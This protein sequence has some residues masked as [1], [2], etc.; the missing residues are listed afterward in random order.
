MLRTR[1]LECKGYVLVATATAVLVLLGMLGL[2]LDL[3]R[4]YIIKNE[5]QTYADAAS[6]AATNRLNGTA[7]GITN[8]TADATSGVN[9][10]HL[11]TQPVS[12]VNVDFA[13]AS[14]G[15]WLANPSPATGYRFARVHA[16]ATVPIYFMPVFGQGTVQAVGAISV[17]GQQYL[18]ELGDGAFPFSPDAH[19]PKPLPADPTG[20]FG[21]I[22]GEL[23]TLRWDPVGKGS[24]VGITSRSGHT[25]V[26][27]TGDMN[28]PGFIPGQANNGQRGYINLGGNGASFL[29]DAILGNADVTPIQVGDTI[30]NVNGAKQSVVSAVLERV[31]QDTNRTTP[32]YYTAPAAAVG[33]DPPGRTY[34]DIDPP[35]QPAAVPPRGNGRRLVV[36]PVNNPTN[37]QVVGFGSFFLGLDPCNQGAPGGNPQPCCAEYVGPSSKLPGEGGPPT[38]SGS[39]GA[40]RIHLFQ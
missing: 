32:S 9:K 37:D 34:Y 29:R 33:V 22:K 15:P 39:L 12:S 5:L 7:A 24:K 3:A 13:T 10:W 2:C 17:A 40:F 11:A 36:M 1:R 25:V 8:A 18:G 23:Y 14:T 28:T 30:D 38:G 6:I 35:G 27:C 16:Q 26:G 21:F 31:A 20:N 19:V 4:L